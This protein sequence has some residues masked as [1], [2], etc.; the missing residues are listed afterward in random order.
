MSI[1]VLSNLAEVICL[2]LSQHCGQRKIDILVFGSRFYTISV[3]GAL[4]MHSRHTNIPQTKP[5]VGIFSWIM[6]R[7]Q[8]F[9]ASETTVQPSFSQ[10]EMYIQ[11]RID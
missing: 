4:L 2:S 1:T 10:S 3:D 6:L 9:K 11:G 7:N 8:K 5:T